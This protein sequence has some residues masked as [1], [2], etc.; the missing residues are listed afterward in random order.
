MPAAF[1]SGN[2]FIKCW[3]SPE[4][5]GFGARYNGKG[6]VNEFSIFCVCV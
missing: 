6:E 4:E 1:L 3:I 2:D 5:K